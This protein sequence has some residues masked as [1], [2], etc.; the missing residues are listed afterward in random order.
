MINIEIKVFQIHMNY[1]K[2]LFEQME[3]SCSNRM[4][5]VATQKDIK[6]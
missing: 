3:L 4:V 5:L 6:Q 2:D 1:L